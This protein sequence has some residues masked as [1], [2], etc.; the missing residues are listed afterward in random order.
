MKTKTK[1]KTTL[2]G[3]LTVVALAVAG[4]AI[5]ELG[6]REGS[7]QALATG[8]ATPS[9][10]ATPAAAQADPSNWGIPQGEAATRRHMEAGLKAGQVD[11]Q[12]GREIMYYHDPMVPGKKFE[13]PGKSPFMDMMLVPAYAGAAGADP[14][15]IR[16]SPRIQQNLG[17]RT[18]EVVEGP[19]AAEVNA[20][21]V[22]AWNERD[23]QTG[24]SI[25]KEGNVPSSVWA[26]AQV[27]ASE[28]AQMQVGA[29]V[30]AHSPALPGQSLEGRVQA[31][32]PGAN[33]AAPTL[34]VRI[35]LDNA[36][37]QLV[38]GML[39]KLRISGA[40]RATALSVPTEAVI[41]TGLRELVM[42]AEA[43]GAFRPVEVQTG[44]EAGSRTEILQGLEVGK[45]VVVSGQFLIDSEASLKGVEARSKAGAP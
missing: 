8:E 20:A 4:A 26:E 10:G 15:S 7:S 36:G 11:P 14:G 3:L 21:G 45:K 37:G 33:A 9:T 1:T 6:K 43:Q 34:K 24:A 2:I 39:V 44:L 18:T 16:V 42:V 25:R 22:I 38:P 40:S 5:Y 13:A 12:T 17:W 35:T 27:S 23:V 28:A 19:L 31:V 30:V 32:R 29:K 41:R